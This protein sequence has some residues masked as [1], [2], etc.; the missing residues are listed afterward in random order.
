MHVQRSAHDQLYDMLQLPAS[1]DLP[2]LNFIATLPLTTLKEVASLMNE[3]TVDITTKNKLIVNIIAG[4]AIGEK[5]LQISRLSALAP[6]AS[7]WPYRHLT[8]RGPFLSRLRQQSNAEE[9]DILGSLFNPF[10]EGSDP[11]NPDLCRTYWVYTP[12]EQRIQEVNVY[13]VIVPIWHVLVPDGPNPRRQS[14]CPDGTLVSSRVTTEADQYVQQ[15]SL[16]PG[17]GFRDVVSLINRKFSNHSVNIVSH[18]HSV[19]STSWENESRRAELR[20]NVKTKLGLICSLLEAAD[21]STRNASA[22]VI[23]GRHNISIL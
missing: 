2:E 3:R 8:D 16:L 18:H 21:P 11:G 5:V 14:M 6:A 19:E 9:F 22:F 7:Y 20:Q 4:T 23:L 17:Q 12:L 13:S 15:Y 10:P 1:A